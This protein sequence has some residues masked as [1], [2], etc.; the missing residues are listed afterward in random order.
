MATRYRYFALL[1]I[2][3]VVS[4]SQAEFTLNIGFDAGYYLLPGIVKGNIS[5]GGYDL[6]S[7]DSYTCIED[8]D[9][10]NGEYSY[11]YTHPYAHRMRPNLGLS[12]H[13]VYFFKSNLGVGG[14]LSASFSIWEDDTVHTLIDT[15]ESSTF[16]D[17]MVRRRISEDNIYA[18]HYIAGFTLAY[19]F[20]FGRYSGVRIGAMLGRSILLTR[21]TI[22]QISSTLSH[23]QRNGHVVYT[24]KEQPEFETFSVR[25]HSFVLQPQLYI[26][27]RMTPQISFNAGVSCP[28][29][30]LEK[31]VSSDRSYYDIE[32]YPSSRF[33]A[34]N[35]AF[36]AGIAIHF[37]RGEE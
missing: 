20:P 21:F 13:P 23:Q 6:H 32:Y 26:A 7:G 33:I 11:R 14:A 15:I 19:R 25:Y 29:S 35:I 4:D 22:D 2:V 10:D 8:I 30:Y 18:R 3:A 9:T 36:S 28:L 16:A 37:T 24:E 12:I 17:Y 1:C 5:G 34:G 27:R 31:G